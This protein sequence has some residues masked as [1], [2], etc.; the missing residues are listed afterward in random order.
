MT[1]SL[2][3]LLADDDTDD[4]FLFE[5]ALGELQV[6]ANLGIVHDGV[7][8]MRLLTAEGK[9]LPDTVF[10]DLNMP[11]K[12]GFECLTEIMSHEKLRKLPVIIFSTSLDMDVVD[13]LYQHGARYYIR[14]PGEFEK[15]K[16]VILD[17]VERISQ[18]DLP[19]PGRDQ[20]I[21]QP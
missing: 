13:L 8:L 15:L 21:L 2:N 9:S 5:E 16:K 19:Q 14:K 10:L 3:L 18:N 7:Q 4:C 11:L 12:S 20:F 6:P 1:T 17:A